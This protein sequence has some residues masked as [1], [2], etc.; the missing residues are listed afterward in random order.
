M[1]ARR[2]HA[3]GFT[4]TSAVLVGHYDVELVALSYF[5]A[6]LAAY[7]AI[8]LSHRIFHNE[9]RQSLWIALG[10]LAMGSGIWSMHFIG[11]QAFS[12]PIRMGY[13]L[14]IT[15]F[16]LAA[17]IAVAALALY[18]ASR[19]KM[20]MKAVAGGAAM[21]ATGICIMHYSGMYAMKMRPGI[22]WNPLLVATSALI[23]FL[24]SG[25][26]LWIVVRLRR[27]P[28]R[29]QLSA[30]IGA[31]LVMGFAVV[32]M[33][34]TG[35][36]AASFPIGAICGAAD[37]LTGAWTAGPIAVFTLLLSLLIMALAAFD[38]H[39]QIQQKAARLRREQEQR[40]RT[41]ALHDSE[42]MLR[43]RPSFQQEA[44]NF[45]QRCTINRTRFDL[46]YGVLRVDGDDTRAMTI[47]AD[48][49][50]QLARPQDFL[51][52][53]GRFEFTLL[54]VRDPM[55]GAPQLLRDQLLAACTLPMEIDGQRINPHAYVGMG[56]FP[57]DG[58]SP[59]EL[60]MAAARSADGGAKIT[61][62]RPRTQRNAAA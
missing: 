31:A 60:L 3:Q 27:I 22:I 48:R 25:V 29:L 49:L 53:Y 43:N 40:V 16:S 52:R 1:L 7:S 54:R 61:L 59:R 41:L 18:T 42:T 50:R 21:M 23:A 45:I 39:Q 10:A 57:D 6:V 44:V 24:A 11:M 32:G 37:G 15:V 2:R 20:G 14:G 38:A 33:H 34:Y 5:V 30:R 51:A 36:A 4:V 35:M 13:D 62:I 47:V 56:S 12:L 17:A 55:E 8:D 26:A 19:K 58:Q 28:S 46:F 9:A